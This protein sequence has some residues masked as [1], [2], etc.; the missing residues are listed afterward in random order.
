M[1]P[2]RDALPSHKQPHAHHLIP[3]LVHTNSKSLGFNT[4]H[5]TWL[6]S[7]ETKFIFCYFAVLCWNNMQ[8]E[9]FRLSVFPS[10]TIAAISIGYG[11][12]SLDYS[13]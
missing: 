6:C 9:N 8:S 3:K 5:I 7:I 4:M 2:A 12:F 13:L 11:S 10:L 1:R